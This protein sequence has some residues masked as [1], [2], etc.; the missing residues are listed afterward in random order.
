EELL[1]KAEKQ[2]FE[3]S[4]RKISPGFIHLTEILKESFETI[5]KLIQRKRLVTGVPTGFIDFD[6]KTAGLQPGDLVIVAGR[7]GMG[8][9]SFCLNVAEHIGTKE[10]LPVALFSLEMSKEQL[11]L[12]LLCSQARINSTK[13]RTGFLEKGELPNLTQAAGILSDASIYI[14]DSPALTTLDIRARSRRFQAE[15]GLSLLIVDYLQLIRGKGRIES[16][17]QEISEITRALKALAK[18]L[19]A[20]V[21]AVSQLSRAVEQR[22]DRRPQLSDLRESGA[23][24][25]DADVVAFLYRDEVYNEESPEKGVAEVNI[26]KQRNGPT[27]P[28]KL[29][30]Q[31]EFTRFDN[32]SR[33]EVF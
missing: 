8:K 2:I 21:M 18:E 13:L 16:R 12:R 10:H 19:A 7:P 3:I 29:S 28:V 17:Q 32:L 11:S 30:F 22:S 6:I 4:E 14:D 1:H 33:G 25:Q 31:K 27:G 15:H 5:D 23:I 26:A 20:P 24:E 9:T